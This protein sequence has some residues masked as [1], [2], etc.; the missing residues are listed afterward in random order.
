VTGILVPY[1]RF[2]E[3]QALRRR[4]AV[5]PTRNALTTIVA[6]ATA[7]P[8]AVHVVP[9]QSTIVPPDHSRAQLAPIP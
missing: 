6:V 1:S 7:R 5:D 8:K 9:E 4:S 3:C 2:I